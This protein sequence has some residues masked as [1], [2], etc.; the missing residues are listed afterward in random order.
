M[1]YTHA[2]DSIAQ[3]VIF[4]KTCI[5]HMLIT[6]SVVKKT[7]KKYNR[8][9][10]DFIVLAVGGLVFREE[11]ADTIITQVGHIHTATLYCKTN[12]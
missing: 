12:S 10:F 1:S 9:K 6:K 7:L 5:V 11:P 3:S 2:H 4:K 8:I